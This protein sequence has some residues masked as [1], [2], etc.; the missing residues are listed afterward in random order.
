MKVYVI[1]ILTLVKLGASEV[2]EDLQEK[3]VTLSRSNFKDYFN[4]KK[5]TW[6]IKEYTNININI[7][8]S[9]QDHETND[10]PERPVPDHLLNRPLPLSFDARNQW[11]HCYSIGKI[12]NQ[13]NCSSCWAHGV[14]DTASDRFCVH[15]GIPLEL[16]VQDLECSHPYETIC[17]GG[18]P[19]IGFKFWKNIGLVPEVCK[20]YEPLDLN[21]NECVRFCKYNPHLGD[22]VKSK[23]RAEDVYTVPNDSKNIK[24]ELFFYGPIQASMPI[25]EDF[26]NDYGLG[27]S[28]GIYKHSHGNLKGFHAVRV[29]GYGV[30]NGVDYWLVANSWG[31]EWGEGG[32]F[33][34][35]AFQPTIK[36]EQRM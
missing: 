11:P 31:P 26:M 22:Y 1:A 5:L 20:P 10:L 35:E 4:Q 19:G 24:A 34:I 25:Y 33:R 13:Y 7:L 17:H 15:T 18:E 2:D 23:L 27:Y 14:A 30:E 32:Y 21:R 16:S 36:F 28:T 9:V 29:I 12:R 6:E 8:V 3:F